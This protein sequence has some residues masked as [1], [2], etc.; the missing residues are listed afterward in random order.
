MKGADQHLTLA[1][2]VANKP[3]VRA[4]LLGPFGE[5]VWRMARDKHQQNGG[6]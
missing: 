4:L 3:E 2:L 6:D 5:A 1:E